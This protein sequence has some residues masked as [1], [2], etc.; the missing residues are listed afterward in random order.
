MTLNGPFLLSH[1]KFGWDLKKKKRAS[2]KRPHI[3]KRYSKWIPFSIKTSIDS[4]F[5]AKQLRSDSSFVPRRYSNINTHKTKHYDQLKYK[6]ALLLLGTSSPIKLLSQ[7]LSV[8]N[9][10]WRRLTWMCHMASSDFYQ[11]CACGRYQMLQNVLDSQS[12]WLLLGTY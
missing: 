2:N 10:T 12:T 4:Y 7:M 8:G 6:N 9:S 11:S 1:P 5:Y 3:F